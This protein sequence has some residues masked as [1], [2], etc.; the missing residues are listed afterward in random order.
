MGLFGISFLFISFTSIPFI[1]IRTGMCIRRIILNKVYLGKYLFWDIQVVIVFLLTISFMTMYPFLV[2]SVFYESYSYT[3]NFL[4]DI[5]Y[6]I[7]YPLSV[8]SYSI[9]IFIYHT[10]KLLLFKLNPS[11]YNQKKSNIDEKAKGSSVREWRQF[12]IYLLCLS[13][14]TTLWMFVV[15]GFLGIGAIAQN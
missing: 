3:G 15:V 9:L 4:N 6:P 13:M 10:I 1:L 12:S 8:L 5:S 2:Q 14:A 7:I 11:Y